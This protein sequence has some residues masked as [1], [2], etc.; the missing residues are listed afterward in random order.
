[1]GPDMRTWYH[2]R[3]LL[4]THQITLPRKGA[5]QW[6]YINALG[7]PNMNTHQHFPAGRTLILPIDIQRYRLPLFLSS[8]VYFLA[9]ALSGGHRWGFDS[10]ARVSILSRSD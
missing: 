4:G 8:V 9:L 3:H 2:A 7:T 1:M 6:H 5:L 10:G